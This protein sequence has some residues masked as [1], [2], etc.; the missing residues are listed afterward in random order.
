MQK[1]GIFVTMKHVPNI[2]TFIRILLIPVFVLTYPVNRIAAAV[3]FAL[4]CITDVIDGYIA[5][6]YDAISKFGTLFDPLAD[7]LLQIAAVLCL[8][9]SDILPPWVV[10]IAAT[11]E[12]IMIIG[13]MYLLT[14]DVVV[15]SNKIGKLGSF[16]VFLSV[17]YLIAIPSVDIF[18]FSTACVIGLISLVS[19]INYSRIFIEIIHSK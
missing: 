7:K 14:R 4:A 1:R 15:P 19:L 18:A 11:K 2:L 13:A 3:I 17:T 8:L 10:F 9:W 16:V 5:R 6:K 12:T